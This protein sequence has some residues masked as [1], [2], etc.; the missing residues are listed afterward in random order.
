MKKERYCRRCGK[1][2]KKD[3]YFFCNETCQERFMESYIPLYE[4]DMVNALLADWFEKIEI[5]VVK[6]DIMQ[7][8]CQNCEHAC[9]QYYSEED[10]GL[11]FQCFFH[12]PQDAHDNGK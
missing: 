6:R 5:P 3:R 4:Q 1:K 12:K 9:K 10:R 7:P 11:T 8:Q 2:L